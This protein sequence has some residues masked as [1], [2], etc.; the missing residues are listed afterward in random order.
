MSL[1]DF[2]IFGTMLAGTDQRRRDEGM[3]DVNQRQM[4]RWRNSRQ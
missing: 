4:Q 2:Y 3:G 1:T